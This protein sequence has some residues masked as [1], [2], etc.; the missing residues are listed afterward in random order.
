MR[1]RESCLEVNVDD[2]ELNSM[3]PLDRYS[4]DHDFWQ[5]I[6]WRVLKVL[7]TSR[8]KRSSEWE[9]GT[10]VKDKPTKSSAAEQPSAG[11][12]QNEQAR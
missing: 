7:L 12:A 10:S 5:V 6:M 11:N 3:R 8:I 4:S 9:P 1:K 2:A